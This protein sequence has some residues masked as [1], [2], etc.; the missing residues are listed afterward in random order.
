[1]ITLLGWPTRAPTVLARLVFFVALS[2]L[3]MVAD[4]RGQH[5][6]K[7]RAGLDTLI[8]P[9]QWIATLPVRATYS[10]SE[11]FTLRSTLTDSNKAMR[12][13]RQMLMAKLHNFEAL[14]SENERL[15]KLL[16]SAARVADRAVVARLLQ[17]SQEPFSRKIVISKGKKDGV[18]SGQPLID[19]HGVMG[20]VTEVSAFTSRGTLITDPGHALP[21][22]VNRNALRAIAFGTGAPAT[23]N[24]PYLT[25]SA[26]IREGDLLVT[27]GMGGRFPPGYPVARISAIVN[28]PNEAFLSI[29]AIPTALLNH[30]KEVLLIWPGKSQ[31]GRGQE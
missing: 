23:L 8:F 4:H 31:S 17:V 24:I 11:F 7:I 20:Q 12:Q 22:L 15:R 26:D 21:V 28:D 27:S 14:E 18:Y 2:I 16:D 10:V 19:A 5:L 25:A 13:E 3:L 1:M 9:L 30:G 29:T 6:E